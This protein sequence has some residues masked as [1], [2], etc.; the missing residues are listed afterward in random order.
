MALVATMAVGAADAA[1]PSP[2]V[3]CDIAGND[4]TSYTSRDTMAPAIAAAPTPV[5]APRDAAWQVTDV[6]D[7][8]A[9]GRG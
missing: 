6:R 8:S 2:Q 3:S 9:T 4:T 5:M 7:Q 1:E